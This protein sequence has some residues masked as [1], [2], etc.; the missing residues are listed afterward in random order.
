METSFIFCSIQGVQVKG[1]VCRLQPNHVAFELCQPDLVL[2]S[3][4]VIDEFKVHMADEVAYSGR[5]VVT[6]VINL[7][8]LLLCEVKLDE[9]GIKTGQNASAAAPGQ[10]RARYDRWF[11]GWQELERIPSDFKLAAVSLHGYLTELKLLSEQFELAIL[12]HPSQDR[13][14]AERA[15]LE[16]LSKPVVDT[17]DLM[18]ERFLDAA[19]ALPPELQSASQVFV[20]RHLHPLFL[21]APFGYRTYQKP[22]GYAGDYEMMNMIHRNTFEGGSL[23]AKMIHYWLVNQ[24]PA[25]SVRVRVDYLKRRVADEVI[26]VSVARRPARILNLGC[27]PARE[28]QQFIREHPAA[29]NAE[30]SLLDFDAETLQHVTGAVDRA[31]AESGRVTQVATRRISVAQLIKDS[32]QPGRNVLGGPYDLIYSGGLFD[33]LSPA[34]CKKVVSLFYTQLAPGG[35]VV[36]ANMYDQFRKFSEMLEYLLDWHLIYRSARE[37]REFTPPS[38]PLGG[39]VLSDDGINLFLEVRKPVEQK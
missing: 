6:N 18:R 13:S 5:A 16:S 29:D 10:C 17:L 33:Y 7:G 30:I 32:V 31:K 27:G 38:A 20:G 3:S 24:P 14:A 36:V 15:V 9:P 19:A 26:R 21:C 4:E 8:D 28:I 39:T 1:V 37:M 35:V 25:K 34:V 12:A 22:L 11:D 23:Y 2:R